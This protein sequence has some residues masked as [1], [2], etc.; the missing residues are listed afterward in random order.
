V[1]AAVLALYDHPISGNAQKVRFLLAELGLEY[2]RR[3]VPIDAS[4]SCTIRRL[5]CGHTIALSSV[6]APFRPFAF[7]Q[8]A[9][10]VCQP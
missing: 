2:E 9:H 5:I 7:S 10:T 1:S 3:G 8:S 4:R 6:S